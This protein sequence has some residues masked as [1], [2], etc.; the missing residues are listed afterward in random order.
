MK[1]RCTAQ[2][3]FF[4]LCTRICLVFCSVATFS[5]ANIITVT[6][7]NDSGPGSL[8]HAVVDAKDGDTIFSFAGPPSCPFCWQPVAISENFDGV[9]PPALPPGWLATNAQGP[10]PLWVT[11]DSGLP[12]P[13]ADTTPNSLFVD[14]PAVISDK[15]LDGWGS[16]I[17]SK[18]AAFY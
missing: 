13:P 4:N 8:R 7:T 18:P 6:N 2:S 14:D 9:T 10:P 12:M 1:K 5:Y 11:S 3:A 17:S 16:L 15:R